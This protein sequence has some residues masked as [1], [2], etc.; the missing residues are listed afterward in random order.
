MIGF[1]IVGCGAISKTHIDAIQAIPDAKLVAVWNRTPQ[2][3]QET[4]EKYGCRWVSELQ[5]LVTDPEIQVVNVCTA[6]GAHLE[7]TLA[8]AAAGKHVL[9]E[10]PLEVTTDRC[11]EM[12]RACEAAGVK[13]GVVFPSRTSPSNQAIRAKLESGGFGKL[14]LASVAVPWYRT[15]EY[16]DSGDWRGTWRLDGGGSLMNQAIHNV[17]ILRWLAG[18][19]SQVQAY[20]EC[21]AHEGIEVE[22]TALAIMKFENGA[23]GHI[24][25]TTSLA[26]GYPVRLEL[27]GTNGG[28]VRNGGDVF[29]W[30]QSE[31]ATRANENSS[32]QSVTATR[33]AG[34]STASDPMAL[35]FH[36]HQQ[37]I[38]DFMDA[39]RNDCQPLISGSEGRKSVE[40]ITAI[41]EAARQGRPV[42]LG[43]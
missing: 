5:E 11:D 43:E 38:E 6:S 23:L 1:G 39:I 20:T 7:P 42:R 35:S 15:Q 31:E 21:L 33:P 28:L 10:K 18:P 4:A 14:I 37:I 12:I 25:A 30:P 2:R 29:E 8:A 34:R 27:H 3:A 24:L 16:Y 13:L 22:D 17:D 32:S 19:V 41:Y 40:L 9:V 26:P 36:G